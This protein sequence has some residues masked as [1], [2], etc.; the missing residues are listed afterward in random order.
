MSET[1]RNP[2]AVAELAFLFKRNGY[3]RRL[4]PK[5]R[6][7]EGQG[8]KKGDEVRLVADTKAELAHLRRLLRRCGFPR[9]RAF[10]KGLQYR[11]PIYGRQTVARFLDLVGAVGGGA[12]RA[13]QDRVRD[14]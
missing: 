4:N 11:Q 5:R 12:H 7:A 9:G 13:E 14:R 10:V 3:V 1:P 2:S 6:S 8:Y